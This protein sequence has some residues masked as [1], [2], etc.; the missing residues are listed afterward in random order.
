V[1]APRPRWLDRDA[2]P[3]V[4]PYALT[5]GRTRPAD[6]SA[7]GLLDVVVATGL[8][9]ADGIRPSPEQRRLL[10][11]CGKPVTVADLASD[12]DLPVGVVRI[13]VGDL[14]QHG[15]V[16]VAATGPAGLAASERL[17]REVLNGLQ[18]L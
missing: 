12:I 5:H 4:R 2:G 16:K 17:L 3:F 14:A 1:S 10:G 18:A 15:L 8:R 9:E 6:E 11:L 13:L 7:P